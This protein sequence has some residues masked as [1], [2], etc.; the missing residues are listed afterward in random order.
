MS[1]ITS[2]IGLISGIDT[3]SVIQQLLSIEARPRTLAQQ[4]MI[5]LQT[6]QTAFLDLN[7]RLDALKTAAAAFN[8]SNIFESAKATSSDEDVLTGTASAG[9]ALG[10]FSFIVDRLVSTQQVMSRGFAD[11][12]STAIGATAFTFEPTEGRLDRDTS[13]SA[14]NGGNG[15]TRG[16]IVIED[17]TGASATIDLSRVATV[18]EVL[19]AINSSNGIGVT[20]SVQGNAIVVA[21]DVGGA[22]TITNDAGSGDVL[23]SLGLTSGA[24][25]V[26]L[27]G[28][29]VYGIGDATSLT[30][31]NDGNGVRITHQVGSGARDFLVT[32]RTG[33]QHV[34]YLGEV[35]EDGEFKSARVGTIAGLKT[36]V[37]EETGGAVTLQVGA[38]GSHLELVDTTGG[39]GDLIVQDVSGAAVDLGF[40]TAEGGT[41][42]VA[43]ATATG[44]R[45][46]AGLNST[47]TQNLLGGTG[48]ADGTI[49][50]QTADGAAHAFTLTT[51]GSVTDILRD[52]ETGT[53]GSVRASLD[54]T[55]TGIVLTDLS[56]SAG[57]TVIAG[58]AATALGLEGTFDPGDSIASGRLH[59]AFIDEATSLSSL[60]AGKGVGVGTFTITDSS[61]KGHEVSITASDRTIGDVIRKINNG[62]FGVTASINS[63]GDGILLQDDTGAG[64]L[65]ITVTDEEGVVA[66]NLRLAGASE[67][68]ETTDNLIDGS[69]EVRV[70][71]DETSSLDDVVNEINNAEAGVRATVVN[72]GSG[73]APFRLVLTSRDTGERGRF[74]LDTD[75]FDLGLSTLSEGSDS[76]VFFGSE[77]AASALLLT[78][79]TNTVDGVISGVRVDLSARSDDPV[80]LTTTRDNESIEESVGKF[81][82]AFNAVVERI[83]VQTAYDPETDRK[84]ALFGDSTANTLRQALHQTIQGPPLNVAG[85]FQNLAQVGVT[86]GTGGKLEVDTDKLREAIDQ[87][88][89][90]VKNLFAAKVQVPREPIPVFPDRPDAG[91]TVRN[92]GP[93]EFS[94]LGVAERMARLVE[95]YLDPVSGIMTRRNET[96]DTQIRQ[97]KDRIAAFDDKLES[98][99]QVLEAQF[100]AM[101]KALSQLQTQQG[102]LG[103]LASMVG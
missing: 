29:D 37:E 45:I 10:S 76:R 8:T 89:E 44:R 38:D 51:G 31:L 23:G 15:I 14:L 90:A 94:S 42:T 6:Q 20:A 24:S 53:G 74:T 4:R 69:F 86:I 75:G 60:R 40:V 13:L 98:R 57:A 22:L 41:A 50:I 103:T 59:H 3:A 18:S 72:D 16:K 35:F 100:A 17:S 26:T 83:D 67:G 97:Q 9:A 61:G 95:R 73:V 11:R 19:E 12:D 79:G 39:T 25:G 55:G 101:E 28:A 88:P 27:T 1:G 82:E 96:L 2:G 99:R 56:G 92:T 68:T 30:S 84:A 87:D 62:D 71:F 5:E 34:V 64:N 65:A 70:E 91:I 58:A 49:T 66:K 93:D 81:V 48:L 7:T 63:T 85:P 52:I 77:D 78:S 36:R 21:D 32:D 54:D 80:T 102:S 47:L 43:G 46:Q 33:T